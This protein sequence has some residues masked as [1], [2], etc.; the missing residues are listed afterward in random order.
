MRNVCSSGECL[1]RASSFHALKLVV[2]RGRSVQAG[3]AFLTFQTPFRGGFRA[4][5][6]PATQHNAAA[7]KVIGKGFHSCL[8]RR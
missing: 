7:P 6:A 2:F 1:P 4:T 5:A 8:G 3:A